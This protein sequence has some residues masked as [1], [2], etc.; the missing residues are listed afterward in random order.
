ME[1]GL[2]PAAGNASALVGGFVLWAWLPGLQL[3][4]IYQH[5]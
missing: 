2:V 5:T 1:H 4:G 3:S